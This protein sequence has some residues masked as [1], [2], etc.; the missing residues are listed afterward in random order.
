M[1][2]PQVAVEPLGRAH[3]S[4]SL[5]DR[6][7][8]L[9]RIVS[10]LPA[11]AQVFLAEPKPATKVLATAQ[12][13]RTMN[14]PSAAP[15]T[16]IPAIV[17]MDYGR[18]R[19]VGILGE[20]MWKWGLLARDQK[21]LTGVYD[22]FWS[23]MIRWLALGGE[24]QPGEEV[25]LR[26]AQRTVRTGEPVS[27]DVVARFVPEQQVNFRVN[28]IDP[29]GERT[30]PA[31]RPLD[32]NRLRQRGSL[33]PEKPGVYQIIVDAP[34]MNP[35]RLEA[36][37]NVFDI[38]FERLQCSANPAAMRRLAEASGGR[39]LDPY[40]PNE[41]FDVLQRQLAT[42][43]V[44]PQPKYVWDKGWLLVMLLIW[45]GLEWLIRKKGGLL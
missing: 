8:R 14:R 43:T 24:F 22:R 30:E 19:V 29:D 2:E 39:F 44:P 16:N 37:F 21:H 9:E 13:Q 3:P 17:T 36:R 45:A 18:G 15:G 1:L 32:G 23:N 40:K 28:V 6:P 38:D 12:R 27:F 35:Q 42:I 20:G 34:G 7:D 5:T 26:L 31:L 41:L 25:A 4:F 11:L 10:E 33:T